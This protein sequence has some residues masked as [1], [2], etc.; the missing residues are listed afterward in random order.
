M[1]DRKEITNWPQKLPENAPLP[2]YK[3]RE[4]RTGIKEQEKAVQEIQAVYYGMISK[5]D[6]LIGKIL[7]TVQEEGYWLFSSGL[8]TGILLVSILW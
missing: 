5:V 1:Y 8:I 7:D 4:I 2:L 3:Q 6:M